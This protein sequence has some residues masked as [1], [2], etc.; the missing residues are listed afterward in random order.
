[1]PMAAKKM[2]SNLATILQGS[3]CNC[4]PIDLHLHSAVFLGD[5]FPNTQPLSFSNWMIN[6]LFK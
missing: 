3:Y 1:M 2:S 6:L 5:N 4:V